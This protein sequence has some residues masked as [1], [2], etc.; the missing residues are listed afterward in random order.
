MSLSFGLNYGNAYAKIA[1]SHD[2][3]HDLIIF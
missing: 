2:Y 1:F 3:K